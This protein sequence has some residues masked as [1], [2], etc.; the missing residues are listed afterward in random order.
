MKRIIFLFIA[1]FFAGSLRGQTYFYE[2]FENVSQGSLPA[3]WT[4]QNIQGASPNSWEVIQN[5]YFWIKMITSSVSGVYPVEHTLEKGKFLWMHKPEYGASQKVKTFLSSPVITIGGGSGNVLVSFY[6]SFSKQS[7]FS[8]TVWVMVFDGTAWDT[9]TKYT[10]YSSGIATFDITPY[11]NPYLKIGFM[12]YYETMPGSVFLDNQNFS[13]DEITVYRDSPVK[14]NVSEV[15][16]NSSEVCPFSNSEQ[17][18][19]HIHSSG[20]QT[21]QNIFVSYQMYKD[22]N[23]VGS[24]VTEV[25]DSLPAGADTVYV[26]QT[27][28]D[29]SAPGEYQIKAQ[30]VNYGEYSLFDN[31][32]YSKRMPLFYVGGQT[33]YTENFDVPDRY[34]KETWAV[35]PNEN[36]GYFGIGVGGDYEPKAMTF[37][38]MPIPF[39]D[40]AYSAYYPY[41]P[42]FDYTKGALADTLGGL[43]ATVEPASFGTD[44]TAEIYSPCFILDNPY[45]DMTPDVLSF[46]Y[47]PNGPGIKKLEC[48]AWN[49]ADSQWVVLNSI[50][51]VFQNTGNVSW[52][53]TSAVLDTNLYKNTITRLKFTAYSYLPASSNPIGSVVALDGV[54]VGLAENSDLELLMAGAAGCPSGQDSLLLLFL[55]EKAATFI[56]PRT[57]LI[58]NFTLQGPTGIV[59]YADTFTNA[60]PPYLDPGRNNY[61]VNNGIGA[62]VTRP[63]FDLSVPGY[64]TITYSFT[65]PQDS[66]AANNS[67]HLSFHISPNNVSQN[68]VDF[69]GYTGSNLSSLFPAWYE[70]FSTEGFYEYIPNIHYWYIRNAQQNPNSGA[71]AADWQRDTASSNGTAATFF[72]NTWQNKDEMIIGGAFEVPV[73]Q[74]GVSIKLLYDISMRDYMDTTFSGMGERASFNVYAGVN[75]GGFWEL[76]NPQNL[77]IYKLLTRYDT[78]S[79]NGNL[80]QNRLKQG[81]TDTLDISVFAGE[82]ILVMFHSQNQATSGAVPQKLQEIFLDNIRILFPLP[83]FSP[84]SFIG[85]PDTV[86]PGEN[87]QHIKVLITNQGQSALTP[88]YKLLY[89]GNEYPF[90]ASQPIAPGD[91]LIETLPDIVFDA[92]HE[93]NQ[94]FVFVIYNSYDTIAYNDTIRKTLYVAPTSFY[95]KPSSISLDPATDQACVSISTDVCDSVKWEVPLPLEIVS[96]GTNSDKSVCF[97]TSTFIDTTIT[98]KATKYCDNC[99]EFKNIQVKISTTVNVESPVQKKIKVYPNPVRN[100]LYIE[101]PQGK[102]TFEIFTLQGKRILSGNISE[103]EVINL[104]QFPSGMYFLK[105]NTDKEVSYFKF[106]KE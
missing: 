95:F 82:K 99:S 36:F 45:P 27:T 28:A 42:E 102:T 77:A 57:P 34:I 80:L 64:Y 49:E 29:L 65:H 51:G 12:Y 98:L 66:N 74:S 38:W 46:A 26:F 11:I 71:Y 52:S 43:I 89:N 25:L 54:S 6:H 50:E 87:L 16:I 105:I 21:A 62:L 24:L 48:S 35:S 106:I 72:V 86:C 103:K 18:A 101:V 61:I 17:V 8:D 75:C 79:V 76:G 58:I 67:G 1:V 69:T 81:F 73:V 88:N 47:L 100:E 55:A 5:P 94:E 2:N 85:F 4:E 70:G 22:G 41:G 7:G 59:T 40:Y 56:S 91:T 31:G 68:T 14:L 92:L 83:D 84:I 53:T 93:G 78:A 20:T 9:L 60:F 44:S 23:P 30:V 97:Q 32:V 63:D 13:V 10:S 3:N 104:S 96:G 33:S 39:G 19:L 15:F 37:T 90:F